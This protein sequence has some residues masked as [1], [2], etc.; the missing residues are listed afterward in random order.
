MI[1]KDNVVIIAGCITDTQRYGLTTIL[2]LT[3]VQKTC[4]PSQ[5]CF[6]QQGKAHRN[7]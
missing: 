5:Y 7:G 1:Q 3:T 2:E 4:S 6:I